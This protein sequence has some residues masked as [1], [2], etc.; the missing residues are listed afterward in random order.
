MKRLALSAALAFG[1]APAHAA[2]KPCEQL[3]TEIA[4]QLDNLGV[5]NYVLEIVAT[6]TVTTA[7]VIGSCDGGTRKITYRKK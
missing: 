4:A 6:E 7:A 5:K 3:Q 2:T 1:L